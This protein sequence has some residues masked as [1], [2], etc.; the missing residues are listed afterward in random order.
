MA[1]HCDIDTNCRSH[2]ARGISALQQEFTALQARA[3]AAEAKLANWRTWAQFVYLGGG[4]AEGSD[5]EL[6]RRVCEKH[7]AELRAKLAAVEQEQARLQGY[8]QHKPE[9][10]FYQTVCRDDEIE[11]RYQEALAEIRRRR[12]S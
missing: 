1:C 12:A 5:D 8:V 9:C 11:R 10:D 6:R 7:D 2:G 4:Q 3:E